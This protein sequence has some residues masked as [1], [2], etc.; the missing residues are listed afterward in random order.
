MPSSEMRRMMASPSIKNWNELILN[1]P[2]HSVFHTTNWASVLQKAYGYT[3]IYFAGNRDKK[4]GTLA[5]FM[6]IDSPFTGKRGVSLP[7]ADYCEPLAS[8]AAA[9]SE[10][11]ASIVEYGR[12]NSWDY[13]EVRGGSDFLQKADRSKEFLG[14]RLDLMPGPETIFPRL[15]ESTRRNIRK[16]RQ[17][18][19][20]ITISTSL[21]SLNEFYRLH[22]VTR[23]EQG[24]PSQP[25]DFFKHC[26][27]E[28]LAKNLGF[29]ALASCR[30]RVIAAHVYF[31]FGQEVI[32]KYGASDKAFLHLR[33][34]NL[35][36]WEAIVWSCN[37]GY[38]LFSFGRTDPDNSGLRQFKSGWG[39]TEYS[40]DYYRYDL[41]KNS[42]TR[43]DTIINPFAKKILA[44]LP[45][46]ALTAMGKLLYR[47]IG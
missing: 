1:E 47:H 12:N 25:E 7:F 22:R 2:G 31:H 21:E 27:E 29:I 39:A 34:N 35:L 8:S 17:G 40:I 26:H 14:H 43:E 44:A 41:R 23:R 11:F 42:F 16:A 32:Y 30:N 45:I 13:V 37:N 46:P 28:I 20:N 4:S 5:P 24:L 3:P 15:R 10:L 9:F 18:N 19:L 36:M 6:E 33:A 38:K